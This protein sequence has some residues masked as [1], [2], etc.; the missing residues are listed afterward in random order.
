[1]DQVVRLLSPHIKLRVQPGTINTY[2]VVVPDEA[3]WFAEWI[4][5]LSAQEKEEDII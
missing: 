1:M 5:S 2:L 4:E 3:T